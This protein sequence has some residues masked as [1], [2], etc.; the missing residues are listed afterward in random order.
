MFLMRI[1][2]GEL[3]VCGVLIAALIAVPL[4]LAWK[5]QRLNKGK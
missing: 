1:G 5:T 3:L 4:L 2:L